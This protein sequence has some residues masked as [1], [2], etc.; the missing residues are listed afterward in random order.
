MKEKEMV[1]ARKQERTNA[2]DCKPQE[3]GEKASSQLD[4]GYEIMV[5]DFDEE[6]WDMCD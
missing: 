5:V 1:F 2:T 3:K 6:E 4:A